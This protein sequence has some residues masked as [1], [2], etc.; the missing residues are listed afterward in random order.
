MRHS[1]FLATVFRVCLSVLATLGSATASTL[2]P[3]FS[4]TLVAGGLVR[5]TAMTIA[6]DGRIFVC[7]QDGQLRVIRDGVLLD[8]P[9]HTLSVNS[10]GERGLLGVAFDPDFASNQFLYVYYTTA[11]AP[12]HNRVSRL[13]ANGDVFV[14]GSER[15]ILDLEALSATNHNGGAIHF[16]S[17]G[18][19]YVAVGDNATG[20]NSQTLNNR[21]GKMLRI[22]ADGTIPIDNPF[23]ATATGLNKAIW[24]LGLRNPFT[25]GV[26]RASRRIFINDVGQSSWEE[27]ND[28]VPGANYGWPATEG[29]T[30]KP[31]YDSP[32]YAYDRRG[33]G[34]CAIAGGAFYSPLTVQFPPQYFGMYFFADLCGGWIHALDP[35]TGDMEAFAN[36]IAAPVDLKVSDDGS[37][38][39]LARGGAANSGVLYRITALAD[40]AA[41]LR[42]QSFQAPRRAASGASLSLKDTTSNNGSGAA[43]PTS[44]GFWFSTDNT[45]GG[46]APL[47]D[48]TVPV[49]APGASSKDTTAVTLPTVTAGTYYLIAEADADGGI[50]E[51]DESDNLAVRKLLIGPDLAVSL[52]T[53]PD[54]PDSTSSTTIRVTTK[55][56]GADLAGASRT[57]LYRSANSTID[58]GDTLIQDF[59]TPPLSAGNSSVSEVTLVLPAGTYFLIARVDAGGAVDEVS[60]SNNTIKAKRTVK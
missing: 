29:P 52:V 27:V 4:E 8:D 34:E 48:R 38:Y 32:F 21:L 31:D 59:A 22:N 13:T 2:P 33:T 18:K 1:G 25:F 12:I 54:S 45:R 56:I 55:N 41:N 30:E 28:G 26:D 7:Q 53:I 3:G 35:D 57:R 9:F 39:Y 20:S 42:I 36:G 24:A 50:A 37:L 15:P 5:P 51:A 23:N 10:S 47:G 6:P 19:L 49:L 58:A 44:T 60:E 40:P 14:P 16:G 46:D 43:T 11:A 17:D